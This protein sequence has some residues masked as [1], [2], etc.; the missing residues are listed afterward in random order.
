MSDE[1]WQRR[2]LYHGWF[3]RVLFGAHNKRDEIMARE[4]S[5]EFLKGAE[6]LL[7]AVWNVAY[8][9]NV[10][11]TDYICIQIRTLDTCDV[12]PGVVPWLL[13]Q[14]CVPATPWSLYRLNIFSKYVFLR[15]GSL[16]GNESTLHIWNW[17]SG[18]LL[19]VSELS[20]QYISRVP[21]T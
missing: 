2:I 9:L 8:D 14:A 12:Y 11:R 5:M 6:G 18:Q 15:I 10:F 21:L 13:T 4:Q 19:F 1:E 7:D 16:T 17:R 3:G 20:N